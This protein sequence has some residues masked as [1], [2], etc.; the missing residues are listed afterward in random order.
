MAAKLTHAQVQQG[1]SSPR[2]SLDVNDASNAEGQLT[3]GSLL[4]A[5]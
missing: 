2:P 1:L 4:R 5:E 3:E